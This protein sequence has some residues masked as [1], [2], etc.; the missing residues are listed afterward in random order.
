[1]PVDDMGPT[2][3]ARFPE[4]LDVLCRGFVSNRYDPKWLVRTIANTQ[5]YQRQ[6]A[7]KING[8]AVL[9]FASVTPIRLRADVVFNALLQ[10]FGMDEPDPAEA[11]RGKMDAGPRAYQRRPRFVFDNLFAVD[12]SVAKE[13][14]TGNIPQSLFLMNSRILGG[15][16]SANGNSRLHQILTDNEN[17]RDAFSELYLLML[18]REPSRNELEICHAYVK[19]VGRRTEGFEDLMW[20]LLNSSEFISKR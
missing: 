20:S 3:S 2:R 9:P 5:A 18:A 19:D 12:P 14:I 1:M 10:V 16:I 8:E 17:D 6:V 15:V 11:V 7:E 4:A 13:D